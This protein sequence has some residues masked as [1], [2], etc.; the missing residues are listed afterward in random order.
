MRRATR[1]VATAASL[2]ACICAALLTG[3]V[4]TASAEVGCPNEPFRIGFSASLPDCRAYEMVSP[5]YKEDQPIEGRFALSVDGTR[6]VSAS[7]GVFAG[8][9]NDLVGGLFGGF[10]E[11]T[12]EGSGWAPHSLDPPASYTSAVLED[13]S[14]DLSSSFWPLH[15]SSR[16]EGIEDFYLRGSDGSFTRV[17]PA[18]AG[19]TVATP[20]PASTFQEPAYLGSSGALSHSV[21]SVRSSNNYRLW[22]GDRT[23]TAAT[24]SLYEYSGTGNAEPRLVGVSNEGRLE[25]QAYVNEGA[26]LIGDC[27]TVLGGET[28]KYNAISHDGAAVF[29][30]TFGVSRCQEGNSAP[31]V[32]EVYAR[33]NGETTVPISEPPLETPG[34]ACTGVCKEDENEEGGHK[35]SP[36]IFEGASE[37][38][39]KAFIRTTQPLVNEDKDET[40]DLYMIE[41]EGA[42]VTRVALVSKGGVGDPS[43]GQ[44]AEVLGVARISE[45]GSHVYFVA[46][47]LLTTAA[48]GEGEAAQAGAEN[49]YAYDTETQQTSFVARLNGATDSGIWNAGNGPAAATPDGRFLVFKSG[50]QLTQDDHSG[51]AAPQIFRYDAQSGALVRVSIGQAGSY[52]CPATEALE[53]FNCGGNSDSG[54]DAPLMIEPSYG[55]RDPATEA[56]SSLTVS[57]DGS[58]TVNAFS[59]ASLGASP[60]TT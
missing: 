57:D 52:P 2:A 5:P 19:T 25:G 7:K 58:T 24:Q 48:N 40:T 53:R 38:G 44:S 20:S 43:P 47:G 31:P 21:F 42:T 10:Y 22:P 28:T 34:R 15:S 39:S 60:W 59:L 56:A 45:D 23:I 54:Q 4:A 3:G 18:S 12:R 11:F 55:K 27:G 8:A 14:S 13:A 49:L 37:D 29:F 46:K 33:V 9:E 6:V 51:P 1:A 35:R 17:G 36:G 32:A 16:P 50:A 26:E 41:L 30:T